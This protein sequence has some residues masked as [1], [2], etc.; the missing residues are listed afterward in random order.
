MPLNR[1][2]LEQ[3]PGPEP[4]EGLRA[5]FDDDG[6]LV[7]LGVYMGGERISPLLE[8][9]PRTRSG[10]LTFSRDPVYGVDWQSYRNGT[11]QSVDAWS[12]NSRG[13]VLPWEEWGRKWVRVIEKRAALW[14]AEPPLCRMARMGAVQGLESLLTDR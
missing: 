4:G 10:C 14:I 11:S 2:I 8:L 13:T 3:A 1:D 7:R 9:D 12:D 5:E 6:L